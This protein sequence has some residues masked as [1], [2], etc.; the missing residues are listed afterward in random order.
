[1]NKREAFRRDL[2]DT[3]HRK[4]MRKSGKHWLVRGVTA[5]TLGL[6][7]AQPVVSVAAVVDADPQTEAPASEAP[8]AEEEAPAA[9][10]ATPE[11]AP[12]EENVSDPV[13]ENG[14]D[15]VTGTVTPGADIQPAPEVEKEPETVIVDPDEEDVEVES[16][17]P[18]EGQASITVS[19]SEV[20]YGDNI[21]IPISYVKS[22]G[23]NYTDN[24]DLTD[25]DI[26]DENENQVEAGTRLDAGTYQI[27]VKPE[28]LDRFGLDPAETNIEAGQLTVEPKVLMLHIPGTIITEGSSLLVEMDGDGFVGDDGEVIHIVAEATDGTAVSELSSGRHL[29]DLKFDGDEDI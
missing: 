21:Q 27:S 25:V 16:E 17:A 28:V 29:V 24:V 13:P 4:H 8:A 10:V 12:V 14:N 22:N 7:M 1:M 11:E 26:T 9:E 6:M 2:I 15:V 20:I 19:N 5:L 3:K 23:S 18:E